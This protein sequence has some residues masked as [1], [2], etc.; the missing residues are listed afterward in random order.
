MYAMY[1][2]ADR[3]RLAKKN[4]NMRNPTR[5]EILIQYSTF[6]LINTLKT[7]VIASV[8]VFT[9]FFQLKL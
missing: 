1:A 6:P 2:K 4:F 8:N 7:G 5:N 9:A 3:I